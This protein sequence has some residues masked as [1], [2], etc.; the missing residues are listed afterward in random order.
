MK[1]KNISYYCKTKKN[2]EVDKKIDQR[3]RMLM[4]MSG[5]TGEDKISNGYTRGSIGAVSVVD[6]M[7]ENSLRWLERILRRD[8]TKAARL[9]KGNIRKT[10]KRWSDVI[11]NDMKRAGVSVEDAEDRV[12][13]RTGA[14]DTK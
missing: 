3:M 4:W 9:S 10:K 5:V 6:K 1:L 11:E 12:E 2:H 13:S 7:R 14:A 8:E